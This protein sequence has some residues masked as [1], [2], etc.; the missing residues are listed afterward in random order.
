[1]LLQGLQNSIIVSNSPLGDA[2]DSICDAIRSTRTE[3]T[4]DALTHLEES[5]GGR[6]PGISRLSLRL[7]DTLYILLSALH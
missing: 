4:E 3:N 5:S 1:M 2:V 7:F 6:Y